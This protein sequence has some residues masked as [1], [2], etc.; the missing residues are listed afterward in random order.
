MSLIL[1]L[2]YL[3]FVLGII[4]GVIFYE[5]HKW[6]NGFSSLASI[7]VSIFIIYNHIGG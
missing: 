4:N 7:I 1:V 2:G 5:T 6:L 3:N